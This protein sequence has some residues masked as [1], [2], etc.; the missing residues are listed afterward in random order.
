MAALT[1]RLFCLRR[2]SL[3][4]PRDEALVAGS[5]FLHLIQQ[6]RIDRTEYRFPPLIDK[7]VSGANLEVK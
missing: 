5:R 1:A 6:R 2:S 7:L 4:D 3:C